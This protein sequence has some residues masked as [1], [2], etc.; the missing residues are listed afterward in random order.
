[1]KQPEPGPEEREVQIQRILQQIEQ[2][3]RQS[4]PHGR[5]PLEKTEREVVEIGQQIR[6]ILEAELLAPLDGG[7]VG[8]ETPCRCGQTARYVADY[9][10]HVVTLNGERRLQRAYYYCA[11]CQQGFCPLDHLLELGRSQS[12]V[13][14]RALVARL[15]SYL[16]QRQAAQELGALTGVHLSASTVAAEE[17]AVGRAL[18]AHWGE[19]E[20]R[21]W[22]G[23]APRPPACPPRLQISMDG[24]MVP[25]GTEWQEAKLGVVYQPQSEGGVAA[26]DYYA[27]LAD[28]GAFGR[29]LR[30]L[31]H[32]T[33]V[34]Y[35]PAVAVVGDGAEWIWQE[36]A[37]HFPRTVEILDY[38]HALEHLWAV[39][40][41]CLV[42]EAA[43]QQWMAG[44]QERLLQDRVRAVIREIA[45]WEA[46]T[47]AAAEVQRRTVTYL[48]THEHR[49]YYRTFR[50][51]GFHIGSGVVEAGCKSVVQARLKGTGMRW[52]REGAE[53]ILHLRAAWCSTHGPDFTAAARQAALLS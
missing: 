42:E 31:A 29:R 45:R 49:M 13:G 48:R 52:S 47:A 6:E 8:A 2:R 17:G 20:Q 38:Y 3:L 23:K 15:G 7:Y 11:G 44:V 39:G 33:G 46:P 18:Q 28:S 10:R 40:R 41:A 36:S 22:A 24:V 25:I 37:K 43:V 12:S 26:A 4:L 30:T 14:V 51:Q 35:C 19:A 16:P 53:A 32:Q 50:A 34:D 27:T 1:M 21:L 5:Q 9:E